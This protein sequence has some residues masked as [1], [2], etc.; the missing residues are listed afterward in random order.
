[1]RARLFILGLLCVFP[2]LSWAGLHCDI[3]TGGA[4][5]FSPFTKENPIAV[6]QDTPDY[7]VILSLD[8]AQFLPNMRLS[9]SSDGQELAAPA[10]FDGSI[11]VSLSGANDFALDWAGEGNTANNGVK[12]K[13]YIK[14]VS[15]N[16][17]TLPNSYPPARLE[18]GKQLGV[19]YP[20]M[21][22]KD[23]TTLFQFGA[24]YNADKTLY[25][26]D[27]R[28]NYAVE[29]MRVV[30]IKFGWLDYSPLPVIPPGAHLTFTIDGMSG[31]STIDVPLGTGVYMAAPSCKLDTQH[32][33][34]ELGDYVKHTEGNFPLEG[35][36]THFGIGFTCSSMTNNVELTFE[37]ANSP[38]KGHDSLAAN[39]G[40]GQTI[41][42]LGVRLYNNE[43]K[44][45][46]MGVKQ[47]LGAAQQGPNT[48]YFD[49]SVIQT[50]PN[51]TAP[52]SPYTGKFSAKTNVTISYY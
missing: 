40:S 49:A 19:E 27:E 13:M 28:H 48:T 35:P 32:Q 43:G 22:G 29:S 44:L 45:V 36:R 5:P 39:T 51:V 11:T 3:N 46:V 21:N 7:T 25:K 23:D 1:M 34:V 26:F 30:L 31:I 2:G 10:N 17:E 52:M 20:I 50:S 16:D 14:A 12:M 8:Y 33:V 41:N 47:S 6:D 15:Y 38:L 9:C 18:P 37:D 4:A 24:Q 42:G